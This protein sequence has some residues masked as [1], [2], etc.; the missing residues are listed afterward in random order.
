MYVN[1]NPEVSKVHYK[2]EENY[3]SEGRESK[4]NEIYK[5]QERGR[6][7]E[8]LEKTITPEKTNQGLKN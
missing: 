3:E 2:H 1:V 8:L 5:N 4:T 7:E 6:G